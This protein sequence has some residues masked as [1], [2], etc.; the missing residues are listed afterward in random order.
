MFLDSGYGTIIDQNKTDL[1][2]T[3]H[4]SRIEKQTDCIGTDKDATIKPVA[5]GLTLGL[6][7]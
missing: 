6:N 2:L 1:S 3:R 7:K 5:F 4:Q